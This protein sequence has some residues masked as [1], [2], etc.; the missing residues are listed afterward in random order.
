MENQRRDWMMQ[1]VISQFIRQYLDQ[2]QK[3][4]SSWNYEDG[5]VLIGCVQLYKASKDIYYKNFVMN[6]I[7]QFVTDDGMIKTFQ[8][9]Q[10]NID[11]INTGKVLI[12]LYEETGYEKY[13][14]AIDIVLDQLKDHP[15]TESG[16]F[17]HKKIYPNQIWLDGLYM[18]QPFYM[19]CD[20][21]FG[22]CSAC[23]DIINQF[24]NVRKYLYDEN[25]GLY[26][27]AYDE[28]RIQKWAD[29]VTGKSPN[30]W[31]RS[32]GWYF[33]SL[34]DTLEEISIENEAHSKFIRSIYR[35]AIDGILKYQDQE[36]KLFYQV[37]DKADIEGNYLETSGTAMV[38]YSMMKACNMGILEDHPYRNIGI[39]IFERLVELKLVEVDGSLHLS[40]ICSVAGLGPGE[41]RDG[42]VAYYLS[43]KIIH[44]DP[45]GVGSFMM[46]FARWLM[47]QNN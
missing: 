24:N 33:M 37:I 1:S 27:H 26:Y 11:S 21:K 18:A 8:K 15:R 9:D 12:F 34:V 40:D 35:E 25:T 14:R 7:D 16:S 45:K 13:R 19:A 28:A 20:T 46:A 22:Q 5:C 30:F 42:S 41:D 39:E 2:Y 47:L 6:Y 23:E 29:K 31:I 43:E 17:W 38:A 36:S 4:K 10:Y 44:D 3:Y 32:M